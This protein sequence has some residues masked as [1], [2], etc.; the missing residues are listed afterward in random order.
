MTISEIVSSGFISPVVKKKKV[1]FN[2]FLL[3]FCVVI[4]FSSCEKV[5]D[6]DLNNSAKKYI[7]QGIVNNQGICQVK[8]SQTVNFSDANNF[9]A[10]SGATVTVKDNNGVPV[11]LN[12]TAAGLY[13]TNLI[14]GVPTHIYNLAVNISGQQF[15][16]TSQMP[17]QV[18]F[19][20]LYISELTLFGST[21]K[22]A[23]VIF[24]DPPL[25]KNAYHFIQYKNNFVNKGIFAWND[26]FSDGKTINSQLND[27]NGNNDKINIGDTIKVE[28]QCIDANVYSFWSSLAESSTGNSQN[29]SPGN[30]ISNITGGALGFFSAH[31]SQNKTVIAR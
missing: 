27:F 28:M 29:A 17:V 8:I 26:D 12:E 15:T 31:T 5:V 25:V 18:G 7:I 24:R 30:P 6:I 1:V 14:S 19:D 20:S 2:N 3:W 10:I 22:F 4:I 23:T 11:L 9:P 13:E 21:I 16:A